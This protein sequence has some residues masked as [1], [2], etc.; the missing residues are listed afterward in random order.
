MILDEVL[1][2]RAPVVVPPVARAPVPP[3]LQVDLPHV[4]SHVTRLLYPGPTDSAPQETAELL[5]LR[6]HERARVNKVCPE[7]AF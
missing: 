5:D 4:P 6:P 3:G 7:V 1:V 2:E